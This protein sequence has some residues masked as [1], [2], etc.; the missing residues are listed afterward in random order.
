MRRRK[1]NPMLRLQLPR[2]GFGVVVALALGMG[3]GYEYQ[4]SQTPEVFAITTDPQEI[5]VC[6]S[7]G[8]NCEKV[9]LEAISKAQNQILVQAFDFSSPVL[10][11]ALIQAHQRQVIVRVLCDRLQ[12]QTPHSL[13]P[14]LREEQIPVTIDKVPGVAH[15]KVMIIDD[16]ILLTGSFNWSNAANL[17]NAENLLVIQDPGLIRTYKEN[18]KRRLARASE[19][20]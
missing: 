14:L 20:R 19:S 11:N 15:N 17:K 5:K 8:G 4:L 10:A 18:W 9:V 1:T 3:I 16:K 7:P 6:F 13:I 2:N 12:S